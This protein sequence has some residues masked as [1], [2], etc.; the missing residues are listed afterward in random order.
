MT[1]AEARVVLAD[2]GVGNY[3]VLHPET[4][5]INRLNLENY[6]G[7]QFVR[8]SWEKLSRENRIKYVENLGS[9]S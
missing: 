6:L 2:L 3:K 7:E 5:K 1:T 4:G 8:T 9:K